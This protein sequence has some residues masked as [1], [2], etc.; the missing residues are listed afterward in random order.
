MGRT[1]RFVTGLLASFLGAVLLSQG[2]SGAPGFATEPAALPAGSV[3]PVLANA[4]DALQVDPATLPENTLPTPSPEQPDG[5]LKLPEKDPDIPEIVPGADAEA[6]PDAAELDVDSPM[7]RALLLSG[8]SPEVAKRSELLIEA[9]RYYQAGNSADAELLY[10][11]AK[12]P[13]WL[14]E[15]GPELAIAPLTDPADLP[16]AGQVYWREAQAGAESEFPNRVLIPLELLVKNY[17]EFLPG[18]ALYARYLVQNDRADEALQVLDGAIARYP[19][20]PDLLRAQAEV[21]MAR[22]QWIEAAITANQFAIL[23]PEHPEAE[24]MSALARQN[25]DRFRGEMNQ[26]LTRNLVSNIIT[27]AAGYILTGGLL[28][29][30]SALNSGIL[31]MQGESG[32]GNQVAEQVK[33]QLPIVDDPEIR[34]YVNDMGQRL[35][36]LA[37]RDEFDYSFEV[38]MD[39]SLNAFALPG[40]KIFLNAGA[41]TKS[42]SEAELAGLV[43]HEIAH[44]VLSHG[45]QMV[46]QGNLTAS[47][48]SFIPIP[49]VANI[50]AG[51]I[52]SSYSRD[53][54]RQSDILGTKLLANNGYAADGLHNLMIT[55][56]AE[57]GNQGVSW[58]ASHPNPGDRVNYLKQLID[59]GGF[60]RYTYEGVETH[61]KMRHKMNRLI[62]E[63]KLEQGIEDDAPIRDRR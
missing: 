56:E 18:Q 40:G 43:G 39:D 17:P 36:A 34:A 3:A 22:E 27:G 38:I 48:A 58:F 52:V 53:M 37:G 20:N 21:Q 25:L 54:E 15:T 51:L 23:N 45:F 61:L 49:E 7:G 33:R 60:N 13:A 35:A 63:Y 47:L 9:D 4:E 6:T 1:Q 50:A 59:Q 10:R 14:A 2:L 8:L 30:F 16:P 62:T 26:T 5:T 29:P 24:A 28:G 11:A 19:Y 55:L 44:A 12:D 57:Y 42:H 32:L 41:I 31:M 46:T